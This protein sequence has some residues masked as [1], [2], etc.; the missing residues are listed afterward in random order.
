MPLQTR[1]KYKDFLKALRKIAEDKDIYCSIKSKSGSARRLEFFK[2][3][4]KGIPFSFV[5]VHEANVLYSED[6]KKV[7]TALD[8]EASDF[9]DYLD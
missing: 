5:V 4:S 2:S 8:M 6:F 1:I 9:E 7:L 3:D